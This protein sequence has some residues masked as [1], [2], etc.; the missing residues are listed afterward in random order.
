MSCVAEFGRN[1]QM[2][3]I[4]HKGK[5]LQKSKLCS[6][7]NSVVCYNGDAGLYMIVQTDTFSQASG[8][9]C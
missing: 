2:I 4:E 3:K 6:N 1:I 5:S 9:P 7:Q 8:I